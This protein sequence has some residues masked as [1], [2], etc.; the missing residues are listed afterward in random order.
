MARREGAPWRL[1]WSASFDRSHYEDVLI[2]RVHEL[3]DEKEIER[4]Y[5]AINEFEKRQVD[6]G[7][8]VIK[9]MLHISFE[10]QQERLAGPA[11]RA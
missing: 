11:R 4:R 9:C 1:A 6:D 8:V 3:A 10:K 2:A 7:T 5:G